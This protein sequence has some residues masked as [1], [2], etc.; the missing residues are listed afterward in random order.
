MRSSKC[1]I[2]IAERK[3]RRYLESF[4]TKTTSGDNLCEYRQYSV[5][6][7]WPDWTN[8]LVAIFLANLGQLQEP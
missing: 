1:E 5:H 2:V 7:L 4:V 6:V 8:V 3:T